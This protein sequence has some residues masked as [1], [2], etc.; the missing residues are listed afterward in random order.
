MQNHE[1][2][3]ALRV[4]YEKPGVV[5]GN[6]SRPGDL[7]LFGLLAWLTGSNAD[8]VR[9]LIADVKV[10]HPFLFWLK[11]MECVAR[12]AAPRAGALHAALRVAPLSV[13]LRYLRPR[14]TRRS[15]PQLLLW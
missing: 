9:A 15:A 12:R 13:A 1:S 4:E 3:T 14:L 10:V 7:I 8:V 6:K 11:R 5:R 2:R